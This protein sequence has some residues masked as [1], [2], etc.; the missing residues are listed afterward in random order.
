V[1]LVLWKP[2]QHV[3]WPVGRPASE[4]EPLQQAKILALS[5]PLERNLYI[6]MR[7]GGP[8]SCTMLTR[9]EGERY[10][11]TYADPFSM[12]MSTEVDEFL[13]PP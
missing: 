12:Y 7:D 10:K 13:M 11:G 4:G 9:Y 6:P 1:S 3:H 5:A 8:K 2:A